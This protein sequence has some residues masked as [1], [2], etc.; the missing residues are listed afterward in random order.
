MGINETVLNANVSDPR[1][2]DPKIV[3]RDSAGRKAAK[4][5]G[6]LVENNSQRNPKTVGRGNLKFG[7]NMGFW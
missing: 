6:F 5:D 7:H 3:N 4:N 1:S 2:R